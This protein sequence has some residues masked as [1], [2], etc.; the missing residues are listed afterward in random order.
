MLASGR[1]VR[2][3]RRSGIPARRLAGTVAA[4]ALLLATAAGGRSAGTPARGK[5]LVASEGLIDPNFAKTV[6]LLVEHGDSGALGLVLNRASRARV[7]EVLPDLDWA[8]GTAGPLFIG[9][10]VALATGMMLFSTGDAHPEQKHVL[11]SVYAG[12]DRA[13]LERLLREP[14]SGERVKVF[15]GYSG[16]GAGQLESELERGDWHL[17]PA[18]PEAVFSI[19]GEELWESYIERTRSRIAA[20]S[21]AR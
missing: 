17:F 10:P 14:R 6:V 2:Q 20:R 15:V 7:D 11:G 21:T 12:W 5:L 1:H 13:L 16:W 18:T 3:G 19:A 4:L 9:G 8:A